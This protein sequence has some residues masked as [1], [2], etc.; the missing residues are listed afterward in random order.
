[1]VQAGK[2]FD[3]KAPGYDGE[4]SETLLG[5][6]YRDRV[7]RRLDRLG[8]EGL[9]V[10]EI[11]CGT[12]EDAWYM[13]RQG[14]RVDAFDPSGE[15]VRRARAKIERS[16][17]GGR[18]MVAQGELQDLGTWLRPPYDLVFSN[19]GALNC[20]ADLNAFARALGELMAGEG[21]LLLCVMGPRVPWE[22]A[23][24][25]AR[26]DRR[27][28]FRRKGKGR[29]R[30]RWRG[31]PLSYPRPEA[32]GE[33]LAGRFVVERVA[34]LGALAPPPFAESLAR[35]FPLLSGGLFALER[36]LEAFPGLAGFAD[37]YLLEARHEGDEKGRQP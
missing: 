4:F 11:G 14:A 24:F 8:L 15:M 37:H 36:K 10:L 18:V 33:A 29:A 22:W 16:G 21:R 28:A 25:L 35:R 7:W 13:A 20:M 12:G 30:P 27:R 32:L 19:F 17:L 34:A 23:W 9:R 2:V 1:M 6:A 26:G 5:R 3:E 31:M